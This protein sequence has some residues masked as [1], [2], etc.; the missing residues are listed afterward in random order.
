MSKK[1]RF[2]TLKNL[3]ASTLDRLKK[4]QSEVERVDLENSTAP[5][6]PCPAPI[7]R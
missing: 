2:N 6:D 1:N 3:E 5:E 7:K 4:I